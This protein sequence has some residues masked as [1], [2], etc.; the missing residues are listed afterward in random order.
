MAKEADDG[1]R[2]SPQELAELRTRVRELET[3]EAELL[4]T[5]EGLRESEKRYRYVAS[6]TSDYF[7]SMSVQPDGPMDITR[8][9]GTF[10]RVTGYS[11]KAFPDVEAWFTLIDAEDH[12]AL[13][14]AIQSVLS[15]K[16]AMVE[17]RIHTK[18]GEER[19]MRDYI[20]PVWDAA[21]KR[22]TSLIGAVQDITERKLAEK[23]LEENAAILRKAMEGIF[24]A[25]ASTLEMRDPYTAGHERRVSALACAIAEEMGLAEEQ[26]QGIRFAGLIH[27]HGKVYLPSEVLGKPRGLS[28]AET[29]LLEVHP[30]I[31]HDILKHIEFPW[32]VTTIVLQHHERLDGSGYPAG[33]SSD[34]ILAE[35]KVLGIA[36][37]VEA[38]CFQRPY[39]QALGVDRA[40][41]EL[42]K[43]RGTLFEADAVD[44]C[45]K[46][47]SVNG[48]EFD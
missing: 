21:E 43:G 41:Q 15:K 1:K 8:I 31:C 24:E 6:L 7:Y 46:V 29:R 25:M 2:A 38:M 26:I 4:R 47:F 19:W 18:D 37:V 22:V 14:R 27:D 12:P 39:R 35:A 20:R 11:R 9:S 40:L 13:Q 17:Y 3:T 34:D 23:K 44:A 28:D 33:L 42:Q 45:V 16:P 48:F 30:Q 36:D 10:R 5:L 32:P